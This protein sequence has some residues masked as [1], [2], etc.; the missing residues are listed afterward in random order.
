MKKDILFANGCSFTWG[1]ALE[2]WFMFVDDKPLGE[3]IGYDATEFRSPS[4]HTGIENTN[5]REKLVWPHHL[6]NLLD[7]SSVIN[8]GMGCGS[9]QRIIR[10]TLEW[11]SNQDRETLDRTIALIQMTETSRYEYY[12]EEQDNW[13]RCKVD[14]CQQVSENQEVAETRN[15]SRLS[16]FTQTEGIIEFVKDCLSIKQ[17]MALY[18]VE[19]YMWTLTSPFYN[20]NERFKKYNNLIDSSCAWINHTVIDSTFGALESYKAPNEK[21][22]SA[23]SSLH[24][25]VEGH[26]ELAE[27]LHFYMIANS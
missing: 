7:S 13:A 25:G 4:G 8:L 11:L 15:M 23:P 2:P 24:P 22:T 27:I 16:T 9:N 3:I 5:V 10:T 14:V 20:T 19:Y 26:K 21:I 12:E 17:I 6:G 1:G 18:G